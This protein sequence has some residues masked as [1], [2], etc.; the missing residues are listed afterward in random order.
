MRYNTNKIPY[1]CHQF[2]KN[3]PCMVTLCFNLVNESIRYKYK[4]IYRCMKRLP[5]KSRNQ[6]C[7]LCCIRLT[8]GINLFDVK[9]SSAL[10]PLFVTWGPSIFFSF[11]FFDRKRKMPNKSFGG[12]VHVSFLRIEL[13]KEIDSYLLDWNK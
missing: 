1:S 2:I 7:L 3:S 5:R 10:L 13:M 6:R 9:E 8:A 4:A 12:L 11:L